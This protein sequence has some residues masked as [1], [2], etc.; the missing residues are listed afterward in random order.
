MDTPERIVGDALRRWCLRLTVCD[1][2]CS[3]R[4]RSA[5]PGSVSLGGLV[6]LQYAG[7]DPAARADCDAVVFRPRTD[8]AAALPAVRRPQ[9]PAGRATAGIA[10]AL[11]ER[12]D[13][14]TEGAG[15]RGAEVDLI[16]GAVE[17]EPHCLVCWAA[18]HV[19]FQRD[20]HLASILLLPP[21]PAIGLLGALLVIIGCTSY[22]A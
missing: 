17:S 6:L 21:V 10:V 15:V 1:R 4:W 19:V 22:N 14:L 8:L 13:L 18:V 12:G 7:R 9:S 2:N 11:D 3:R 20:G 5:R 16:L